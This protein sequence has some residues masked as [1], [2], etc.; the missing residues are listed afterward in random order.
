METCRS[1]IWTT[2]EKLSQQL[3]TD[4]RSSAEQ[5]EKLLEDL[6]AEDFPLETAC[7]TYILS[8]GQYYQ[9]QL[10]KA[11]KGLESAEHTLCGLRSTEKRAMEWLLRV[12]T[13]LGICYAALGD[14]AQGIYQ[15]LEVKEQSV[16]LNDVYN[17][18]YAH[19]YLGNLYGSVGKHE[20]ALQYLTA[21]QEAAAVTGSVHQQGMVNLYLGSI[22]SR[23]NDFK[24]ALE[25]LGRAL[26]LFDRHRLAD[27]PEVLTTMGAIYLAQQDH[28]RSEQ[29]LS[30]ALEQAR[31]KGTPSAEIEALIQKA[32]VSRSKD[33]ASEA[34]DLLKH[35]L[36]LAETH[37]LDR[38]TLPCAKKLLE[39]K[40]SAGDYRGACLYT[41]MVMDLNEE[42]I[43]QSTLSEL[44]T[45]ELSHKL[46]QTEAE[47]DFLK[48][49]SSHLKR[50]F[51]QINAVSRLGT[52]ANAL[53]DLNLIIDSMYTTLSTIFPVDSFSILL[54]NEQGDEL[55]PQSRIISNQYIST[56]AIPTASVR[57]IEAYA[58]RNRQDILIRD[59]EA[60][61]A[62]YRSGPTA[63]ADTDYRSWAL[64]PLEARGKLLGILQL[65]S[66]Q[67]EAYS[68]QDMDILRIL[69]NQTAV[70]LS[71]ER[72]LKEMQQTNE[73]LSLERER[74]QLANRQLQDAHTRIEQLAIYDDLTG[75]PN[76]HLLFERAVPMLHLARR[77][78]S[79]F[80]VC[81]ID[82]DNFKQINDSLGHWAGDEALKMLGRRISKTLRKSDLVARLGGDEFVAVFNDLKSSDAVTVILEKMLNEFAQPL[83]IGSRTFFVG[84]SIGVSLY[85][86]DAFE[87]NEL[88]NLADKAQYAAKHTGK[89]RYCFYR[90]LADR[91]EKTGSDIS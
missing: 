5:A 4:P 67:S 31:E 32:E 16:R 37:N 62:Q 55:I 43:H 41:R 80:A 70:T 15:L 79:P 38:Y 49:R 63:E 25:C 26:E 14:C 36:H 60:E 73:Q 22:Y 48:K 7:L 45:I 35:A 50:S 2:V 65:Q 10:P 86:D 71:N 57:H 75:L 68:V 17:Y 83:E 12:K 28:I 20:L 58:A 53:L 69:A 11:V 81:F 51:E 85:P 27:T 24:K 59:I 40:E 44:Q 61:G 54:T 66:K 52:E 39:L 34:E 64:L 42:I 82:L 19:I 30:I 56:A 78:Q 3:M 90:Q 1:S 72:T 23:L 29:F 18:A 91:Q 33:K 8:V 76:R 46:E 13:Y 21:G 9:A 6:E 47:R 89:Q 88:L 77:N 74:L 87:F 84:A